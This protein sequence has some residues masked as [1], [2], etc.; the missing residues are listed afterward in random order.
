MPEFVYNAHLFE[1]ERE[2]CSLCGDEDTLMRRC[3][4]CAG[5][6]CRECYSRDSRCN[7]CASSVAGIKHQSDVP[8]AD[9]LDEVLESAVASAEIDDSPVDRGDLAEESTEIHDD[10]MDCDDAEPH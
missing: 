4:G 2:S 7:S 3:S 1:S 6:L 8:A 9:T 5:K 10:D